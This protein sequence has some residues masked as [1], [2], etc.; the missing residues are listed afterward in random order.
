MRKF[1]DQNGTIQILMDGEEVPSG[2]IEIVEKYKRYKA[3]NGDIHTILADATP[4]E[5]WVEEDIDFLGQPDPSFTIPYS[6]QRQINYPDLG[7]QL[8]MLWH[9]L[10][11]SGSL[12]TSGEWFQTINSVKSQYPKE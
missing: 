9:E 2:W 12:S 5:D 10:N 6:A 8:D 1:F 11:N 7:E 3:P 4:G